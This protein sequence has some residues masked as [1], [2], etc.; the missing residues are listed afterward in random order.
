[1]K[2]ILMMVSLAVL[3]ASCSKVGQ[4]FDQR[5]SGSPGASTTVGG[6]D[7]ASSGASTT[8]AGSA[9]SADATG[10]QAAERP[11]PTAAQLAAIEGGQEAK[12][13]QQGITW[14]VPKGWVKDRAETTM[15]TW[16]SPSGGDY[17]F[18]IANISPM[19]ADFPTD[20]SLKAMYDQTV[21]RK[22]N[23]QVEDVRWLELDGVKGVALREAPP[24]NKEDPR[25]I[26][27]ITYRKYAGQTQMLILTLNSTGRSFD[28]WQDALYGIL[29]STKLVH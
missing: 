12:W 24:E 19:S 17:G 10:G 21:E 8:S 11:Q 27:W 28:K 3:L 29:Y 15:F 6:N 5:N 23:G 2:R 4:K 22:K 25:R 14:T 20:V 16:R 7:A 13:D 18:L 1:M 26:Q 9:S